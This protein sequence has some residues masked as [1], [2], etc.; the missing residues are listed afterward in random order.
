MVQT[1]ENY[2]RNEMFKAISNYIKETGK[3]ENEVLYIIENKFPGESISK[4][5]VTQEHEKNYFGY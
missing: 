5:V 1:K 2:L 3:T 4:S